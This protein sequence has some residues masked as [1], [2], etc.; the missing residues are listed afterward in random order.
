MITVDYTSY[1][2]G[3]KDWADRLSRQA[4]D[5]DTP[6]LMLAAVAALSRMQAMTGRHN[7]ALARAAE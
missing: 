4:A 2:E 6:E 5:N 3:Q 7:V 1:C